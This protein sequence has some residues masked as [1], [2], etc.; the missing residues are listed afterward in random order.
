M[1]VLKPVNQSIVSPL[2][3][4]VISL[5]VSD[6][7]SVAKDQIVAIVESMKMQTALTAPVAGIVANLSIDLG[8]TI[9][10]GQL[11]C[12]IQPMMQ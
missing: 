9:Q 1:L 11:V 4:A 5:D 3:A 12:E 10:A 6:G 7:Q 2:A 8:A